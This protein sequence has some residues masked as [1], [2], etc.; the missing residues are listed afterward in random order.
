MM[1]RYLLCILLLAAV[2]LGGCRKREWTVVE[3]RST[4]IAVDSTADALADSA[5]LASLAPLRA[6]MEAE[7]NTVIGRAAH[8]LAVGQPE[9][10]LSNFAADVFRQEAG[11]WLGRPVDLAVVNMGG[12]R[13][14]VPEGD[15]TV[16]RI[17]EL[18]PFENEL[19]V[20]WLPGDSLLSL[21]DIIA[22]VGG[23]G[24]S[25]L[26][27]GILGGRAVHPTVGGRPI[28]PQASYAVATNDFL[29]E[30]NDRL[31]PLA[32]HTRLE[33]T[34]EKVRDLFIDYI[35]REAA[36]GRAIDP[37]LDGRISH[38]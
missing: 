36:Q 8:T 27:M 1:Y 30:G 22:R 15:I 19:V 14:D 16:G 23:E 25:G 13:I 6:R 35:R 10:T 38:E 28:D 37:Q 7:M 26:R 4:L 9:S 11:R 5:Y 24:V 29:A 34:G 32:G 31:T 20:L 3:H 17:F 33:H 21:C 18:M 12:L 2:A